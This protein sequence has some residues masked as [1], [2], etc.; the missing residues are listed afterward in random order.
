[1]LSLLSG[2]AAATSGYK[3]YGVVILYTLCTLAVNLLGWEIPGFTPSGSWLSDVMAML[4][5][6]T[7]RAGISSIILK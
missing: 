3:T 2:I 5:L 7:L 6:G 1:M 4:G